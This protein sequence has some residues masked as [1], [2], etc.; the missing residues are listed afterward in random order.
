MTRRDILQDVVGP[1]NFCGERW[2]GKKKN[3]MKCS[4]N[5]V[6][7]STVTNDEE[8]ILRMEDSELTRQIINFFRSYSLWSQIHDFKFVEKEVKLLTEGQSTPNAEKE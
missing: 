2:M 8:N 5:K 6:D 4:L 3:N 7:I 1:A